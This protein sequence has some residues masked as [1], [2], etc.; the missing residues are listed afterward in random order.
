M[1]LQAPLPPMAFLDP[2]RKPLVLIPAHAD[3][4]CSLGHMPALSG[5]QSFSPVKRNNGASPVVLI[6]PVQEVRRHETRPFLSLP[7]PSDSPAV[8]QPH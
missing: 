6:L 8:L 4:L 7:P 2:A 5:P 3:W 1:Y